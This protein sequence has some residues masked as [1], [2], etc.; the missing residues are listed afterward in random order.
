MEEGTASRLR[1]VMVKLSK[2]RGVFPKAFLP[3]NVEL[4]DP[5]CKDSGA[6]GDIYQGA[7]DGKLVALKCMRLTRSDIE[8]EDKFSALKK[9]SHMSSMVG[10]SIV[11][12]Y[13]SGLLARGHHL[14]STVS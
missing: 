10:H 14:E 5:N 2:A 1:Y 8:D 3:S 4:L 9:E 7:I 11:T 6:F 12:Y 13:S